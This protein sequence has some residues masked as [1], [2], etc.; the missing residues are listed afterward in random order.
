VARFE[1]TVEGVLGYVF[2]EEGV[3]TP[4]EITFTVI[5]GVRVEI[6]DIVCIKHPSRDTPVFYQVVEVPVRR[7]ARD[8]EEDLARLGQPLLDETRDYPR[9]RAK[10]IGYVEDLEKLLSGRADLDDFVMLIEH[11][12]PLSKVYRPKPEVIDSLLAPT[13]PSIEVGKIYPSWKHTYRFDL[14]RLL[15]QGLLVVGGVGTGKTTTMLTILIRVIRAVKELGG[16]PHVLIIDKD[17][18]YGPRELVEAAGQD[19]YVRIHVDEIGEEDFSDKYVFAE[20]LRKALGFTDWKSS[21]ARALRDAVYSTNLEVYRFTPEFVEAHIMPV[22]RKQYTQHA[23][24]ILRR[25]TSWKQEFSKKPRAAYSVA[26]IIEML[27]DKT[28]VH[29]DLSKTRDYDRAY[30]VLAELLRRV[31]EEALRDPSFGCIVAVDEAHLFAPERG[32]ISLA[33]EESVV[34]ALRDVIHLIATTGPRNGVTLFAATQ[35]PSLIT[36][37]VTTQMG[38]NIIAHRVEDVDLV[39]IEE[40]M[41]PVAREVR[42]LPRGWALVKGLAAK[43]REPM[44]VRIEAEAKPESTGKTAFERFLQSK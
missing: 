10:Q 17:G 5:S 19:S 24:E 20:M 37:T 34:D 29:I 8:F 39:R 23:P 18:E 28:V 44:I 41:G 11:I 4:D 1:D 7:K 32:G 35:R 31:Y 36:K 40:I 25:L 3:Y 26:S 30:H 9:A 27:R 21:A 42:V 12:K 43:I 33:S 13:G 22:I 38:Q 15:R 6:G 16:K 14:Q 2:S